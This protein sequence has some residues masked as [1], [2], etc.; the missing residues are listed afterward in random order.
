M[1]FAVV[2]MAKMKSHDLKGMQFHNQ[3]ERESKTNPDIDKTKLHLNYD[4]VNERPIDYNKQVKKIVESQKEGTRKTRKDAVLVNELLITSDKVFFDG[5][6]PKEQK[7]FFEESYKLFSERY[8]KQNIAYATVHY[9]EKTPHLHLGVVPMRDGKLQGKNI[10]NRQELQW[11]QEEFPKHMQKLGFNLARGE[12]GSDREHIEMQKFKAITLDQKVKELESSLKEVLQVYEVV[13]KVDTIEVKDKPDLKTKMG[14][15]GTHKVEIGLEDFEH[16]KA[17]AKTSETLKKQNKQLT[18]EVERLET[19]S[20]TLKKRAFKI[21][22]ENGKLM[23]E[24]KHLTKTVD[25]YKKMIDV[26]NKM[27]EVMK[28][29]SQKQLGIGLERMQ[30]YIGESRLH[31][32]FQKLG[33]QTFQKENLDNI[34]PK[35][36]RVGAEKYMAKINKSNLESAKQPSENEK[37]VASRK[38]QDMELDR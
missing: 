14:L 3:R 22:E 28:I 10:F 9:D 5:I 20:G 18:S 19:E 23:T 30:S 12:K 26:L 24:N 13:Q 6:D 11:I 29:S 16:I 21:A 25:G 7:R 17:L 37:S 33:I 38:R 8:G 1:S 34:I 32:W 15:K 31:V 36:E 2:R 4:L 27:V 35:D